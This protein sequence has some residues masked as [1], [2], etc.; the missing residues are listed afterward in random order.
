MTQPHDIDAPVQ[1]DDRPADPAVESFGDAR[2]DAAV[3]RLAE[4]RERPVADHVQ[5]FDDIHARFRDA[6]EDAAVEPPEVHV[7]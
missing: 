2:V 5:V 3:E 7:D 1:G 4:L 6:L